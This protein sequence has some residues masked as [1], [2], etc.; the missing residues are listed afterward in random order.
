[1]PILI[2]I[3]LKVVAMNRKLFAILS[4]F[5]I[6]INAYADDN[7][8]RK[9]LYW[10]DPMMP[11]KQFDKAGK[12]P[13]M[14]MD[15][16]PKYADEIDS[17]N[18]ASGEKPIIS[19][20]SENMQKMGVRTEKVS[21][22]AFGQTIR[23]TGVI[24]EN[25][26]MRIEV[27]SQVEGRITS[28]KVSA[29]GDV[30]KKGEVFYS[31]YSSELLALQNDYIVALSGGMKEMAAA[32]RKRL[33]LLGV[34]EIVL[35]IIAKTHKP[36]DEVPFYI[37]ADGVLAKLEIRNGRYIK[38]GDEIG[39][40][41]DLSKI[42]VEA[43]VT[44]NDLP[45]IKQGDNASINFAGNPT[46][47]NAKVDYIYPTITPE[48][49]TGKVRLVVDNK[50]GSL[51]PAGY[52]TVNFASTSITEML[53]VPSE[54]IL[55]STIGEHIIMALGDGKFQSRIVKIG[56]SSG[57]KTE[58]LEGLNEGETV[59]TS[60]QF[61]IDSESNLREATKKIAGEKL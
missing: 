23:A 6:S 20:N 3:L 22:T 48:T 54:A 13:F 49:R 25:E 24:M 1:L 55:R 50:D 40:I 19:I 29:V 32:A 59:V 36:Y 56:A 2:I 17:S 58:I 35:N 45:A 60:A 57:G 47:Y 9:V 4:C 61:L 30:V 52:A 33:K 21:K 5:L 37:P 41:Q 15:L 34:S 42:W 8:G 18:D 14:D 10:Y 46:P 26:R 7:S 51:K 39:Y 16:V 28:L 53:A 31:L 38:A 27:F 11:E 12:S 44:E 43:A